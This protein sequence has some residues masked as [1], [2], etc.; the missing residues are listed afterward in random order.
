MTNDVFRYVLSVEGRE[1]D[2]S[3][4][5]ATL[6]RSRTSTVRLEHE[7][8]SRSH[9]LLTLNKG[10]AIVKDL[11]SSNGTYVGGKRIS[12]ET[13]LQSGDRVQI[14]AAVVDLRIVPPN[15]PSERTALLGPDDLPPQ[16]AAVATPG[17]PPRPPSGITYD[18]LP[19]GTSAGVPSPSSVVPPDEMS[20][21]ELFRDVDRKGAPAGPG[22]G[23][24]EA[25]PA[26]LRPA[27]ELSTVAPSDGIPVLAEPFPSA[28]AARELADVSIEINSS[29]APPRPATVER[30]AAFRERR[31]PPVNAGPRHAANPF[32]RLL[33]ALVDAVILTAINL[34]LFAPVFLIDYFRG[35]LQTR[36]AAPDWAFRGITALSFLLAALANA[37]YVVGGWAWRGR[38][39]GKSLLGLTVVKRGEI[40]GRGIGWKAALIRAVVLVLAGL[41]LGLGWVWAFFEKDKRAFQD[42]AAGTWVVRSR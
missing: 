35:E 12:R 16:P 27:D 21:S 42:L 28:I 20:A 15:V 9:A 29:Q 17:A 22:S 36:D 18:P 40:G 2:L 34:L 6:G 25:F 10:E 39:P 37:L 14:G 13:R 30:A 7:S 5:E 1:I 26:A 19:D 3:D 24:R 32:A 8:V 31:A 33:A 41:P 23:F 4:G 38:T 11:N